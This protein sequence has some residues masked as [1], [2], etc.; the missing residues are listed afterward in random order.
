MDEPIKHDQYQY[1]V[2]GEPKYWLEGWFTPSELRQLAN[3]AEEMAE[4]NRKRLLTSMGSVDS[5][6]KA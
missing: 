5:K 1:A 3:D 4:A 6:E 2:Y